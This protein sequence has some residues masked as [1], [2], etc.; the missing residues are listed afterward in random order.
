MFVSYGEIKT[1]TMLKSLIPTIKEIF[2]EV[3]DIP[4]IHPGEHWAEFLEEFE[5]TQYRLAKEIGKY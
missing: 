5:I 4:L 1:P 3:R 2:M